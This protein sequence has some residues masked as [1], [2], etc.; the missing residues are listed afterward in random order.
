M[1]LSGLL[2]TEKEFRRNEVAKEN[3]KSD[4]NHGWLVHLMKEYVA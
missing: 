1:A 4:S 2:W 3:M